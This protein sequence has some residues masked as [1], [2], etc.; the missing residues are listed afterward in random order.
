[1]FNW[2]NLPTYYDVSF[3]HE[4]QEELAFI[5]AVFSQDNSN[6]KRLLEPACGTGR[7]IIPLCRK[8]FDCTGFDLNENA[9]KYLDEKLKRNHLKANIFKSDMTKF[10]IPTKKYDGAFCTVDT[11]RHLLTDAQAKQHLINIAKSLKKNAIY[12]LG[13]HLIPKQGITTKTSRWTSKRGQLTVNTSMALIEHDKRKRTETLKV[14]LNAKTKQ[15]N[16][17]YNSVYK[18][19]TYKFSEFMKLIKSTQ[20]FEI[21]GIYDYGYDLSHPLRINQSTDYAVFLLKRI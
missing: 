19:R 13:L 11:F 7:L 3:S 21:E 1:M 14:T 9:L 6:K 18:L 12:I 15:K 17:K 5:M 2:Y 4:M 10:K 20:L 8:G 16:H